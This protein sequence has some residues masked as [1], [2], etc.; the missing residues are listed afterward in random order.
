MLSIGGFTIGTNSLY[1][2]PDNLG[3]NKKGVYIGTDGI[4]SIGDNG[5]KYV[6]IR[7]GKITGHNSGSMSGTSEAVI[8]LTA[9]SSVGND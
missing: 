6:Q 9:A 3:S 7:N 1:S 5:G 8:D 2:G 4:S